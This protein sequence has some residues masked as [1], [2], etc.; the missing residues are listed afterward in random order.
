MRDVMALHLGSSLVNRG[1]WTHR[2]GIR[3]HD[4]SNLTAWVSRVWYMSRYIYG[5]E[6]SL[7]S[8]CH[9]TTFRLRLS[10]S[11]KLRQ[12]AFIVG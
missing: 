5:T 8:I 6:A 3:L 10:I 9:R 2:H 4:V 12:L 1:V 7:V 11:C